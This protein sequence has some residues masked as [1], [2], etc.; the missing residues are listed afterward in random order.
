MHN[1]VAHV[2]DDPCYPLYQLDLVVW[3]L[4]TLAIDASYEVYHVPV[5]RIVPNEHSGM[6][7]AGQLVPREIL[8]VGFAINTTFYAAMLW[9]LT[10]GPFTM[11]RI[12]RRKR[13]HCINCGYD[14]RGDFSVGCPECGWQRKENDAVQP[15]S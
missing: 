14:L 8:W 9:L 15:A 11:R 6:T 12:I 5:Q 3:P 1:G 7:V 13:G 4:R 2:V 10:L